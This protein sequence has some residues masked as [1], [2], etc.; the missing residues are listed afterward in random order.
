[1]NSAY[2]WYSHNSNIIQFYSGY[3]ATESKRNDKHDMVE[4]VVDNSYRYSTNTVEYQ[5][6][7]YVDW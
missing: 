6:N 4:E 3:T 2:K 1:M 7:A 5:N